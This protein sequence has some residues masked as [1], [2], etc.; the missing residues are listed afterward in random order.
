MSMK[1]QCTILTPDRILY[2]GD[3][4]FAVVQAYDGEAGFLYNHAPLV[5]ELGIG[6]VRLRTGELT[7]YFTIEGGF[8]EIND[9]K[10]VILAEDAYAKADLVKDKIEKELAVVQ[11][12]EP[13]G[14]E[15]RLQVSIELTKLK[16]RL[17]V[18]SR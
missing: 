13:K 17:K 7:E 15:E 5:S 2:E 1:L 12:K 14:Y 8:V 4:H 9:N 6:E 18:A 16:A 11:A 10:L 3:V